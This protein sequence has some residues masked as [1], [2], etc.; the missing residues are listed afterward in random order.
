MALNQDPD[1]GRI[2]LAIRQ[3]NYPP[4]D[5]LGDDYLNRPPPPNKRSL[6]EE[7]QGIPNEGDT[8]SFT[9]LPLNRPRL[10]LLYVGVFCLIYLLG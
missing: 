3:A 5:I 8:D 9:V 7:S 2:C 10:F 6:P 4:P 1:L